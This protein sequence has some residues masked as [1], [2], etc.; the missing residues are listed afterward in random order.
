MPARGAAA[1]VL[2]LVAMAAQCICAGPDTT[3]PTAMQSETPSSSSLASRADMT[4]ASSP[5]AQ[6][7]A[8][9]SAAV[10]S[11]TTPSSTT[12]AQGDSKT[13][14]PVAARPVPPRPELTDSDL[15]PLARDAKLPDAIVIK[16]PVTSSPVVYLAPVAANETSS[17]QSARLLD[18]V[19]RAHLRLSPADRLLL[20]LIPYDFMAW[21]YVREDGTE[22]L[23]SR[24][25]DQLMHDAAALGSDVFILPRIGENGSSVT[26]QFQLT[27]LRTR[28]TD[29]WTSTAGLEDLTPLLVEA[30]TTCASFSGATPRDIA[31]AG[32]DQRLP[33]PATWKMLKEKDS[34]DTAALA[35]DPDCLSLLDLVICQTLSI[36]AAND[37]LR[38]F[39]DNPVLLRSKAQCLLRA[40]KGYAAAL[41]LTELLRRYPD[42]L[43]LGR[44]LPEFM[45]ACY[46]NL[47][48]DPSQP[49]P[50]Y[51]AA[52]ELLRRISVRHPKDWA[53]R[54]NYAHLC[55]CL[56]DYVRGDNTPERVPGEC[57]RIHNTLTKTA[58]EQIDAAVQARPDCPQLL[59]AALHAHF[60]SGSYDIEWQRSLLRRIRELDPGNVTAELDVAYS[61]SIGWSSD[62][63]Y[64]PIVQE[65]AKNHS[66]NPA[67][68]CKIADSL[69]DVI[70]RS[71]MFGA[72]SWDEFAGPRKET[73]LLLECADSAIRAGLKLDPETEQLLMK[74]YAS[75][76]GKTDPHLKIPERVLQWAR[77]KQ[78]KKTQG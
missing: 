4:S 69:A 76:R 61:H 56:A 48:A 59:T 21:P 22:S 16:E 68:M 74:L 12:A 38:R 72:G 25:P 63:L 42:M 44:A 75:R 6:A 11:D 37:A 73:D 10:Q 55:L 13:S 24:K 53:I 49:P 43:A 70:S 3:V 23:S 64:L 47:S 57:W 33:Q 66:G 77:D 20:N 65:A 5:T 45:S 28:R 30:V 15:F 50:A 2:A 27:D 39:P 1:L 78:E 34:L 71:V 58:R 60:R 9:S 52:G 51:A 36:E 7:D 19:L 41:F 26:L 54:W 35:T 31:D 17:A 18:S 29:N 40:G 32:M 62:G 67:A 14:S 8:S 46:E